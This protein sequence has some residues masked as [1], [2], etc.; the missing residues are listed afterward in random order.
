MAAAQGAAKGTLE[1]TAGAQS[2]LSLEVIAGGERPVANGVGLLPALRVDIG[3]TGR[4]GFA[5]SLQGGSGRGPGFEETSFLALARYSWGISLG[6][7]HVGLG[8]EAG[9]GAVVQGLDT[10]PTDGTAVGV[11]APWLG[12]NYDL[13]GTFALCLEA[14]SAFAL[15]EV[16]R[17]A[18]FAWLPAGWLG[19]RV[20]L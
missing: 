7:F 6:G 3:F 17:Q 9:G 12:A 18:G 8:L 4:D 10:G 16:N 11:L 20:A 5:L 13:S 19:L 15:L 1:A 14:D 2:G